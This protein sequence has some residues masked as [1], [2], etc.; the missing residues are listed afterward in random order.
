M[1]ASPFMVSTN[2]LDRL[3]DPQQFMNSTKVLK[4]SPPSLSCLCL[5][6]FLNIFSLYLKI[7]DLEQLTS[8]TP[9]HAAA[10]LAADVLQ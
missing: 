3:P 1:K 7:A 5:L 8:D 2:S 4:R 6:V 9:T 10:A